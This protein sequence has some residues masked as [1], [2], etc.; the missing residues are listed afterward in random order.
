MKL[1]AKTGLF[2]GSGTFD[3]T[4]VAAEAYKTPAAFGPTIGPLAYLSYKRA[5]ARIQVDTDASGTVKVMAGTT[6]LGSV[7]FAGNLATALE[8]DLNLV[9]GQTRLAYVVDVTT[10]GT[11][12]GTVSGAV[13]IEQPG[14]M[15]GC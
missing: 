11:G 13:D 10:A 5:E 15:D 2:M 3:A 12:T 4:A 14:I 7:N 6:E 9:Q 1:A 8:I